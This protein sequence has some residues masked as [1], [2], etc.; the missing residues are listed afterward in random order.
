MKSFICLLFQKR[1]VDAQDIVTGVRWNII[2]LIAEKPRS[3]AEIAKEISTS[4]AN[5]SQHLK[6]LELA[7]LVVKERVN[8]KS[9]N[10]KLAQ[11]A[12]LIT[13]LADKPSRETILFDPLSA[14]EFKLFLDKKPRSKYI[15]RFMVQYEELIKGFLAFGTIKE[16]DEIQLL[17]LA[18]DVKQLRKEYANIPVGDKRIVIWSHTP[19]EFRDGLGRKEPYFTDMVKHLTVLYDQKGIMR[20]IKEAYK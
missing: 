3:G 19:D 8:G 13:F 6:L 4:A 5:V 10:Y 16:T 7:G 2:K 15:R 14:L 11:E 20:T 18:D 9:N 12:A 1:A 17:V